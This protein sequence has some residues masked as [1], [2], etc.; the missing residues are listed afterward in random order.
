MI[1]E[2]LNPLE[3]LPRLACAAE[4]AGTLSIILVNYNGMPYLQA[5]LDSIRQFSPEGTQVIL[6]DN[7]SCD[8]SVAFVTQSFPWVHV[9]RSRYNL[10]FSAGNNLGAQHA[11]GDMLLLLN[12]DTILLQPIAPALQWFRHH[13]ECGA[14]TVTMLDGERTPRACTGRFP[15]PLRLVLL[16][17]MLVRPDAYAID[18]TY[19]VDWV[20]GSFMLLRAGIWQALGGMDERYFMYFED[21]ELC[22]RLH[23]I[24]LKCCYFP[25]ISYLHRGGFNPARF[26]L[27]IENLCLYIHRHLSALGRCLAWSF[28]L[29]G[30]IARTAFY[31]LCAVLLR[32]VAHM[33]LWRVSGCA[34]EKVLTVMRT[35]PAYH[36]GSD[37]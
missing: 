6:V 21:V 15:T 33:T 2:Q 25:M 1:D 32:D 36:I 5:C 9:V 20:Q 26:P 12:V 37:E 8:H 18:R 16:S 28:L 10:G 19:D 17:S 7:A 4:A 13:P 34:L 29:S 27:L 23:D 30:C 35:A 14:L 3:D 11:T 22:R 31:F 24:G